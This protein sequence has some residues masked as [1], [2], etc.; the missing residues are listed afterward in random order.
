VLEYF[1]EYQSCLR[2]FLV[3]VIVLRYGS[4]YAAQGCVP[5]QISPLAYGGYCYGLPLQPI[6]PQPSLI[7]MA[8]LLRNHRDLTI[9][10]ASR[11]HLLRWVKEKGLCYPKMEQNF[12]RLIEDG[13]SC[14]GREPLQ[15]FCL[16]QY[17]ARQNECKQLM[18]DN[19]KLSSDI[20]SKR[21]CA[22][23]IAHQ[24]FQALEQG[25]KRQKDLSNQYFSCYLRA[26]VG[27]IPC[28]CSESEIAFLKN[29]FVV[30]ASRM[31]I[32]R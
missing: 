5:V 31:V 25:S 4:A 32:M 6:P 17:V 9:V 30:T 27:F 22:E 16:A 3:S 26:L 8:I 12:L 2:A 14:I 19:K 1:Y 13:T 18:Q 15:F 11:L 20:D 10:A 28:N 23:G 7:E 24:Y 29:V 21:R